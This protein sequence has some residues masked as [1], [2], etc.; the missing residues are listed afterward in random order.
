M[1]SIQ[2]ILILLGL[3]ISRATDLCTS[4]SGGSCVNKYFNSCMSGYYYSTTGCSRNEEICCIPPS[5]V[6]SQTLQPGQCGIQTNVGTNRIVGGTPAAV[7]E[8]PWQVSMQ[9]HGQHVCG[10]ILIADQWVLTAAHCFRENKNPF[11]WT[12]VLGEHDRAVLEGYEKL[13]KVETLF[14][15]SQFD[16]TSFTNDIAIVKLGDRINIDGQYVRSVCLPGMND[17]YDNMICSITGWGA[18]FTGG[19]GTHA[20]YKADLPLIS[21]QVCSYLMDRTIPGTEICAGQ[22]HGGVDSCQGDSGG[23]LVCLKNGKWNVVGIVSWGYSC[24]QAYTPGVYTRVQSYLTWIYQVMASY[25][26]ATVLG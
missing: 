11:A 2:I 4:Q 14:I 9:S 7:G 22:K 8:F 12:V 5:R 10:G 20:L 25:G 18:A 16:E 17:T 19:H 15:H 1:A 13:E 21:N 23:P 24:A 6:P 26:A 3:S